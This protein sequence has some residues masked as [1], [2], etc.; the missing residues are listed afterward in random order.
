MKRRSPV[1]LTTARKTADTVSNQR[2]LPDPK[3]CRTKYL[4]QALDFSK[5]LVGNPEA[6]KYAVSFSGGVICNHPY[7]RWFDKTDR[8]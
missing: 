5:C 6:C 1:G 8:R 2:R 3:V 4:G 7:H